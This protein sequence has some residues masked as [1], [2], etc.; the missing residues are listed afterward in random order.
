MPSPPRDEQV[1]DR[2]TPG[3]VDLGGRPGTAADAVGPP[4]RPDSGVN[5]KRRILP[6][7]DLDDSPAL[8]DVLEGLP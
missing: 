1:R 2:S 3:D 5:R 8:L 6:S 7:V 4:A